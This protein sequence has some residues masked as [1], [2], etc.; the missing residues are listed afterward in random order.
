MSMTAW[1]DAAY[2]E[3][4]DKTY[5]SLER[6]RAEDQTF[7]ISDLAGILEHLYV[8]D[9]NDQGGRGSLQDALLQSMIDAHEHFLSAWKTESPDVKQQPEVKS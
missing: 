4:Y 3:S 5:R 6:R 8:Q 2:N 9:G 1:R 7:K